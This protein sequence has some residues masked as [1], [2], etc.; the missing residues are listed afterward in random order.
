MTIL[1]RHVVATAVS[2]VLLAISPIQLSG[3]GVPPS[4]ADLPAEAPD[5][6]TIPSGYVNPREPDEQRVISLD[7]PLE[8]LAPEQFEPRP[9]PSSSRL[10]KWLAVGGGAAGAVALG[11]LAGRGAE[12]GVSFT[13]ATAPTSLGP[14]SPEPT[15]LRTPL[16]DVTLD[17]T[18]LSPIIPVPEVGIDP[19]PEVGDD[20]SGKK[21]NGGKGK[22]KGGGD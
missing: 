21:G 20:E 14:S 1:S 13:A 19:V 10:W 12:A 17:P 16:G 7:A 15:I 22:A 6:V 18:P 2:L 11:V 3:Q 4:E 8:P 5:R 9:A